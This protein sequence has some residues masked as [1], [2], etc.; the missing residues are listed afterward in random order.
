VFHAAPRLSFIVRPRAAGR[1]TL[2]GPLQWTIIPHAPLS[3]Q[4]ADRTAI[5]EIL[6]S[7]LDPPDRF[8]HATFASYQASTASQQ[9]ALTAARAFT[10]QL[11]ARPSL[12]EWVHHFFTSSTDPTEQG[13]YFVGPVGTGKTHLIAAMYH[14][15]HPEVPCA[16]LHASTL[17]RST[18]RPAHYAAALAER[19]DVLCLDEVEIDDPANEAR[20]VLVLR[21]LEEHGVKLLATSNVKPEQFMANRMGS[22]RFERF[23]QQQFTERYRLVFVGGGDYRLRATNGRDAKGKGWIG[24]RDLAHHALQD[25][26]RRCAGDRLWL[27]F[28]AFRDASRSTAHDQ[29]LARL[30][31]YDHL[32]IADVQI[33][34]TDDALRLLRVVDELYMRPD[35][36]QLYLSSE[37]S[38]A[39]WFHAT[40]QGEGIAGDVAKKFTRTTSRLHALCDIETVA[41]SD[42]PQSDA[43]D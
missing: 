42:V 40:D 20:L 10:H 13:L 16:F 37:T 4:N 43:S 25:S 33:Q 29:L 23:L 19:C 22:G 8:A 27:S 30:T 39:Q 38:P 7:S 5:A 35:A 36:P 28:D 11:Q 15:L 32:F 6:P 34:D 26:Y 2:T 41:P 31:S 17:F 9:D 12:S 18:V 24:P 14:A 1:E 21:A 3:V